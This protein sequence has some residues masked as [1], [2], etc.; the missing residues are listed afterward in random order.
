MKCV[1]KEGVVSCLW[2]VAPAAH[3]RPRGCIG[4]RNLSRLAPALS[5]LH[6]ASTLAFAL[7]ETAADDVQLLANFLARP[8]ADPRLLLAPASSYRCVPCGTCNTTMSNRLVM[9]SRYNFLF[10]P[11]LHRLARC[12]HSPAAVFDSMSARALT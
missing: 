11:L 1:L 2:S 4:F 3:R 6:A 9:I 12:V 8:S 10:L 7:P 5:C